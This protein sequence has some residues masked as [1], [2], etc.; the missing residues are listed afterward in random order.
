MPGISGYEVARRLRKHPEVAS[1]M[2]VAL[3]GWGTEEDKRKARDAGFDE[4]VTK[5]IDMTAI[6]TVLA[7]AAM[8]RSRQWSDP[9]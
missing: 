6:E 7:K 4:H 1:A 3:T 2:L 8:G 9:R 5:P